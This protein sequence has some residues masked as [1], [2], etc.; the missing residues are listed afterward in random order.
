MNILKERFRNSYTIFIHTVFTI[1]YLYGFQGTHHFSLIRYEILSIK[2]MNL[3]EYRE[4]V[5]FL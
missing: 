5:I 3:Y 2:I 4:N 1:E